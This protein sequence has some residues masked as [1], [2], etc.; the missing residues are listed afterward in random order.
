MIIQ[1]MDIGLLKHILACHLLKFP[2]VPI[3]NGCLFSSVENPKYTQ[4]SSY[5][6]YYYPRVFVY[7][8]STAMRT[9]NGLGKG[10]CDG[11]GGFFSEKR[12][13]EALK[14]TNEIY[15]GW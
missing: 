3:K 12:I 4:R 10:P 1:K 8:K 2:L 11:K 9:S 7:G 5:S 6:S 14:C 13:A 15:L